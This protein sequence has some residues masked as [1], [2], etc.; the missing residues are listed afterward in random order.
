MMQAAR[1]IEGA[2]RTA[3]AGALGLLLALGAGGPAQAQ[4]PE[5]QKPQ[6]TVPEIFTLMGQYVRIAYN[7]QGYVSL[8]Y[9]MAQLNVGEEWAMLEVGLTLREGT[10]NM[11]IK[12]EDFK[13]KTPDGTTIAL[14]TQ[15]EYA[16]AGYLRALN[17]RSKIVRD[18]IDYFPVSA[19]RANALRFFGN[20]GEPGQQIAYDQMELSS[21]RASVG[22]LYFHVPGGIK[23]GQH[24]LLVNFNGS[25][26]QVPFRILTKE[27]QKQ[28]E[29]T[30]EDLKKAHDESYKK[31]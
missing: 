13:I 8:G 2:F 20:L 29:D 9:R 27:E 16:K 28:L 25:E 4:Q 5:V 21:T 26:V 17:E 12:R 11:T 31:K 6:P 18:S 23:V 15:Q 3:A 10:P 19:S 14:A 30:W 22:R 1:R 7:N 24:W